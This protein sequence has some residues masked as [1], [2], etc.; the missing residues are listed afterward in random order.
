MPEM[1][2]PPQ[3]RRGR[4]ACCLIAAV[5]TLTLII[6]CGVG[7]ATPHAGPGAVPIVLDVTM[8]E[9][10]FEPNTFSVA[11]GVKVVISYD[12]PSAFIHNLLIISKDTQGRD[13]TSPMVVKT[14]ES[15]TIEA[16]FP[17]AGQVKFICSFHPGMDGT[18]T[19]R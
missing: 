5:V 6:A 3:R 13:Y 1:P 10:V 9:T 18:I 16:T 2:L 11:R 17:N 12:N 8:R 14:G 15:G 4:A 19:V 7:S